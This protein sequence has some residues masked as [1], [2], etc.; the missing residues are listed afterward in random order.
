[1]KYFTVKELACK[2]CGG[3][4]L[5][6]GFGEA[7]DALREDLR[8]PMVATSVCRCLEHNTDIKGHEHSLHI[9]DIP[10]HAAMGQEGA[11]AADIATP[12]ADYR[13]RLLRKARQHGFS[14]GHGSTFLH[15]DRRDMIG[16]RQAEF[17]Y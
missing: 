12:N 11:L 5:H 14:V 15:L 4:A 8:E 3:V 9:F 17:N 10:A 16:L 6:P 2:H 13:G 7:L 1:M